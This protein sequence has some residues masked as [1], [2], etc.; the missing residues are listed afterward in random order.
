MI[1]QSCTVSS[2]SIW[3]FRLATLQRPTLQESMAKAPDNSA[4]ADAIDR[5]NEKNPGKAAT[6][7]RCEKIALAPPIDQARTSPG[8]ATAAQKGASLP[9]PQRH[10]VT[11]GIALSVLSSPTTDVPPSS[12]KSNTRSG[13]ETGF[14]ENGAGTVLLE[15]LN[16]WEEKHPEKAHSLR[17]RNAKGKVRTLDRLALVDNE[18]G[19]NS[20]STWETRRCSN[21]SRPSSRS[22]ID[23]DSLAV[24]VFDSSARGSKP[25][26]RAPTPG[27][28]DVCRSATLLTLPDGEPAEETTEQGRRRS[29]SRRASAISSIRNFLRLE[30]S[31]QL[32]RSGKK[33]RT[34][35]RDVSMTGYYTGDGGQPFDGTFTSDFNDL[36][37]CESL[38]CSSPS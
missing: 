6:L 13:S 30:A 15:A 7:T 20:D 19:D 22:R 26:S 11:P 37:G 34:T 29:S 14:A 36:V 17:T 5:W 35:S 25:P 32:G 31:S 9:S 10:H 28:D 16:R 27:S 18:D 23:R 24:T 8:D 33:S 3:S 12:G 4:L 1:E 2:S 21:N 38:A